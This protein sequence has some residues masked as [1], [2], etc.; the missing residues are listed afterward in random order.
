MSTLALS[1]TFQRIHQRLLPADNNSGY[2]PYV[3]LVYLIMF[4]LPPLFGDRPNW[5]SIVSFA[6]VPPFLA[7][8]FYTFWQRDKMVLVCILGI[9]SFGLA[10]AWFN[11]GASVFF[12]YAAAFCVHLWQ[13]RKGM[14]LVML[15]AASAGL[16]S[17]LLDMPGYFYFPAIVLSILIG[18]VNIYEGELRK[19]NQL[20]KLSQEELQKMAATAERERI[21]R[22]LHDVIGHTF[23]LITVKAQLAHKLAD[24]DPLKSKQELK[25]LEQLSRKAMTEVRETVHRFQQKDM[26]SEIAK[27]QLLTQAAEI[28]L[29]SDIAELPE[30]DNINCALAWVIREAFTNIVKHSDATQCQL[31]FE[32]CDGMYQLNIEDNGSRSEAVLKEGSGLTGM[33]E[34]IQELGGQLS[35]SSQSGFT[36]FV[37]VPHG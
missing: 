9:L 37:E 14:I 31:H 32:D 1:T 16:Y 6:L 7:L 33:R 8:Y 15:I 20:L 24:I 28:K 36:I 12:I 27:A 23:S 18:S 13:P 2:L 17:Y 4:L 22:D 29:Q 10:T 26:A 5:Q 21:A 3:W 11:A 19:K 35:I 25:E 30:E 34:R